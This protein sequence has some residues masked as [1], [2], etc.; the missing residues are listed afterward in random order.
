MLTA[1]LGGVALSAQDLEK[2]ITIDRDIIPAQ[3]AASRPVVFPTVTPPV[4]APVNLRMEGT[5]YP[6]ALAPG[7]T[8][9]EPAATPAAFAPTPWRGYVDFGYFP[10]VDFGLSAGYRIIDTAATGLNICLQADNRSYDSNGADPAHGLDVRRPMIWEDFKWKSFDIAG[11]LA[12]S[13]RI[14][15]NNLLK[16]STDIAYSSW[17]MPADW[18]AGDLG[19]FSGGLFGTQNMVWNDQPFEWSTT[20]NNLRWHINADFV[21]RSVSSGLSYGVG[22]GF[23]IF[24]NKKLEY[25][26][27]YLGESLGTFIP[28]PGNQ[29]TVSFNGFIRQQV[30]ERASV[31]IAVE[32]EMVNSSAYFTPEDMLMYIEDEVQMVAPGSKTVGQVD[33][34]PSVAYNGGSFYGSVGAR[35]GLSVNSGKSFHVAPDIIL[36]VNPD[37][38][39]GAWLKL[40]G[41]VETNT[42]E[43]AFQISRYADPRIAYGLSNVAFTGQLGLR[44]GPFKGAS[45]TLTA[46]YAAANDWLMP[47]QYAD[48]KAIYNLL[49]PGK[50]R[51]WKI[52]AKIDWQYRSL[53]TVA[54]SYDGT[55]GGD[56]DQAWLYWRDRSRHVLGAT[57]SVSPLSPLTVDLGFSARL[58][59]R[60]LIAGEGLLRYINEQD[61]YE[62]GQLSGSSYSLG[63]QTNLWAG[64][65]WKF[66]PALTVFARFDNILNKRA[67]LVYNAD[68]QGF[69]GLFGVGY[70]F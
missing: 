32:G 28:E 47:L 52:G 30:N 26:A 65:S 70:K 3:R 54:L 43:S 44:V 66:T 34:I 20:L 56:D 64:A 59:R 68:G 24:N 4:V 31:G 14:G 41:G 60:Q 22:A 38:R 25:Q 2:E 16:V 48:N 13:Q 18:V 40:G 49:A 15:A 10:T 55:L 53:V 17:S 36:G 69:C 67:S 35:L 11:G 58:D 51:S 23:G 61:Y 50:I 7:I 21:G 46:D 37:A 9:Y 62:I 33:F 63:D 27:E 8:P 12:L 42:M 19:R 29:S 6:A 57:V 1:T 45:L 5:G 39:F